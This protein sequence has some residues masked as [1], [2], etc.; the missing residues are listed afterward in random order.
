M[1]SWAGGRTVPR[2]AQQGQRRSAVSKQAWLTALTAVL[3][4]LVALGSRRSF[5][6]VSSSRAL[7]DARVAFG[8]LLVILGA[9]LVAEFVLL[10]YVWVSYLRRRNA[11]P[12]AGRAVRPS[13][14]TQ[15]LVAGVAALMVFAVFIGIAARG[16]DGGSAGVLGLVPPSPLPPLAGSER[17]AQ[18]FVIHWWIL[19]GLALL[20]LVGV[21]LVVLVRR[22]RKRRADRD[23]RSDDEPPERIELL[24]TVEASL[25]DLEDDPD[26]R[27]AVIRAYVNL[28][29]TLSQHGLARR[30]SEAPLEYLARWT[31]AVHVRRQPAEAL[32][33]LYERARFGLHAVDEGARREA[34]SALFALRH[35][36]GGEAP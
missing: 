28:E 35:E 14:W 1:V 2:T 26:P 13:S 5:A 32:T 11:D 10:V 4:F 16:G 25:E 23:A 36:L 18:T 17:V 3:V 29:Q 8:D 19:L 15:R 24:A 31:R 12:D 7:L 9:V 34:I 21:L 22:R 20:G 30:P 27:E 33:R 6:N